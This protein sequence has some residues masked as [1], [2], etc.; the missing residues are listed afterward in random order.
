[1]VCYFVTLFML[2]RG[3]GLEKA[4]NMVFGFKTHKVHMCWDEW[5]MEE[6]PHPLST[7]F[8]VL[9]CVVLVLSPLCWRCSW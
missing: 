2:N 9:C 7:Q 4:E 5:A 6:L 1:M 3:L 8:V